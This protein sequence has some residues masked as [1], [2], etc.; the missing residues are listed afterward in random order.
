MR[1]P[2]KMA[3]A[4]E[5]GTHVFTVHRG[6][7]P[8][9]ITHIDRNIFRSR[10]NSKAL[11]AEIELI[12]SGGRK[13]FLASKNLIPIHLQQLVCGCLIQIQNTHNTLE[14]SVLQ[15]TTVFPNGSRPTG[16]VRLFLILVH[17]LTALY[18]FG[19]WSIENVLPLII[20]QITVSLQCAMVN[21]F[22]GKQIEESLHI[23][24]FL[25]IGFSNTRHNFLG[26]PFIIE[27][28]DAQRSQ[29]GASACI[30]HLV[31]DGD[32]CVFRLVAVKFSTPLSP[33][34][35]NVLHESK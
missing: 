26:V 13:R 17:I 2:T 11:C 1:D 30:D 25:L 28:E 4:F 18:S 21:N 33:G 35:A 27:L 6:G 3:A 15:K 14:T 12:V 31:Q 16:K 23:F 5:R 32:P 29:A 24:N 8:A 10:A 34:S 22:H 9:D 20:G 7:L 19:L